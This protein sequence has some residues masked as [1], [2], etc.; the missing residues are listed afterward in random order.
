MT[1]LNELADSLQQEL[2]HLGYRV[3]ISEIKKFITSARKEFYGNIK[4]ISNKKLAQM[5][6]KQK[7]GVGR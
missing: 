6:L 3:P 2:D 7:G 1:W 5:Y 4:I